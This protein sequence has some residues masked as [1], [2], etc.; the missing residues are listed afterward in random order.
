MSLGIN[1]LILLVLIFFWIFTIIK[2]ANYQFRK[3]RKTSWLFIATLLGFFG[4]L[5]FWIFGHREV[6]SIEDSTITK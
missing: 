3:G 2:I 5:L 6:I 4:S 1:E